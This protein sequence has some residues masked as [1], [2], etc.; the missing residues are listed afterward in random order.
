MSSPW[1][2]AD[3]AHTCFKAGHLACYFLLGLY[4]RR[5]SALLEVFGHRDPATGR[6]VPRWTRWRQGL[7]YGH[8]KKSSTGGRVDGVE[9]RAV[10]GK[11][12][13]EHGRYLLGYKQINTSVVERHNGT[14]RLRNHVTR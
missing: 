14:R 7:A 3:N 1:L 13:L 6:V 5:V 4:Q 8:V 9:G 11:A 2:V 10:H 12:R